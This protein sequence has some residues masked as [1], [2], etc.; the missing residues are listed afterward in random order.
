MIECRT[1]GDEFENL[2]EL[3]LHRANDK[4][5]KMVEQHIEIYEDRQT[6]QYQKDLADYADWGLD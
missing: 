5:E 3:V 4:C 6:E 2:R 1:C